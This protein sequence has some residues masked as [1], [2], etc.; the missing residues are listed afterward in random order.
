MTEL[1]EVMFTEN[2]GNI[3]EGD[4][5]RFNWIDEDEMPYIEMVQVAGIDFEGQ[6]VI[7]SG[8]SEVLNTNDEWHIFED[9]DVEVL[10]G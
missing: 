10:G 7:V 6:Y 1:Y 4:F 8:F 2:V 5:I 3:E 9:T